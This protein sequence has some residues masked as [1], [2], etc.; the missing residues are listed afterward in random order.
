MVSIY[1][2]ST[3]EDHEFKASLDYIVRPCLKNN[4][5]TVLIPILVSQ[6]TLNSRQITGL[7]QNC[8][9]SHISSSH[10]THTPIVQMHTLTH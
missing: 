8:S 7:I 1:N 4:N 10:V 3:G 6:V 9:P 2:P 5:Y